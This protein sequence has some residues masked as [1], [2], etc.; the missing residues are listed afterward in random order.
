MHRLVCIPF[1]HYNEKARWGLDL[2]RQAYRE[3]PWL[4]GLHL[5]PVAWAAR[6]AE[7]E[8]GSPA[9]TPLLITDG[10]RKLGDSATILHWLDREHAGRGP[11]LYPDPACTV[12]ERRF[13]RRL[14]PQARRLAYHWLFAEP[15]Q[16]FRLGRANAPA[17]Q[18]AAFERLWP[19]L[20]PPMRRG[21]GLDGETVAR[22]RA[23][24]LAEVAAVSGELRGRRWLAGGRFSAADLSLAC[25]L[26]PVLLVQPE[27]GFGAR[28][29]PLD[30]A[31]EAVAALARQL[32]ATR[33]GEHALRMFAEQR[34]PRD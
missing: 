13:D 4:P 9:A 25:M 27:E 23:A 2:Y 12:L 26:S 8:R 11:P 6:G 14:G 7:G 3:E 22:S 17:A 16:L 24:L 31:P 18:A 30:E 1:S 5:L 15:A 33:A 32:R 34:R 19:L 20:A 28:L 29:P 10:R 21:L